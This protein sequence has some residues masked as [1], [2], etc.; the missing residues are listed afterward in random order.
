[1]TNWKNVQTRRSQLRYETF[2][3]AII[4]IVFKLS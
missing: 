3:I 2:L 4:H 1:M